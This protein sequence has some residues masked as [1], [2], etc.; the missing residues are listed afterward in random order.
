MHHQYHPLGT[1]WKSRNLILPINFGS[2]I[3][4]FRFLQKF[5]F[6]LN[7]LPFTLMCKNPN[8][9]FYCYSTCSLSTSSLASYG[10]FLLSLASSWVSSESPGSWKQKRVS[11]DPK[12]KSQSFSSFWKGSWWLSFFFQFQFF[13][14][15]LPSS[16]SE[17]SASSSSDS[18][19]RIGSFFFFLLLLWGKGS[20]LVV[21]GVSTPSRSSSLMELELLVLQ[22]LGFQ[23]LTPYPCIVVEVS[24]APPVANSSM[25]LPSGMEV[26]LGLVPVA[27]WQPTSAFPL[28]CLPSYAQTPPKWWWS[29]ATTTAL[30]SWYHCKKKAP[31]S[32]RR[33]DSQWTPESGPSLPLTIPIAGKSLRPSSL[34]PLLNLPPLMPTLHW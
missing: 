18:R 21:L 4:F 15:N 20:E 17:D 6:L 2:Q 29:L 33:P 23:R 10:S 13:I 25:A 30:Q 32:Q 19:S 5:N 11:F 1:Q 28:V 31:C 16:S 7:L 9:Y 26:G 27:V 14:G 24:L 34:V 8:F 3:L 12:P 22:S